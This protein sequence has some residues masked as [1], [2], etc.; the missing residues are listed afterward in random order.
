MNPEGDAQAQ[1]CV[2]AGYA[3]ILITGPDRQ[4]QVFGQVIVGAG[5]K[6]GDQVVVVLVHVIDHQLRVG[7]TEFERIVFVQFEPQ[8]GAA[9]KIETLQTGKCEMIFAFQAE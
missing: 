2:G 3:A 9:K 4:G 8:S 7:K 1:Y 6:I 5:E